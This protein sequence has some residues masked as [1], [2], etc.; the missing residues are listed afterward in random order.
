MSSTNGLR[1]PST[2]LAVSTDRVEIWS[3]EPRI[4]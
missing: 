3:S 2:R 1:M 4:A